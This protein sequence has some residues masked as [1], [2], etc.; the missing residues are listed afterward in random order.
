M[1]EE[2]FIQKRHSSFCLRET[3]TGYMGSR[4]F[5][6]KAG[7]PYGHPA[8]FNF[9]KGSTSETVLQAKLNQAGRNGRLSYLSESRWGCD[10]HRRRLTEDWVVEQV[11]EIRSELNV[12]S[13]AKTNCLDDGQVPVLL[14]WTTES[15]TRYFAIAGS[16]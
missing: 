10:I 15:I 13:L 8:E 11:E 12:V 1:L 6:V 7:R 4:L 5:E 3:R 16:C 9:G 2:R 14:V